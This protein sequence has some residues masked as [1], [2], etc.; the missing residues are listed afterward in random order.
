MFIE[1][2]FLYTLIHEVLFQ[3]EWLIYIYIYRKVPSQR[4]PPRMIPTSNLK[5]TSS[6]CPLND[7]DE[8]PFADVDELE[9]FSEPGEDEK[10]KL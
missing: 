5:G 3:P 2:L 9:V 10:L 6:K 1:Q 8:C 4:P 7:S